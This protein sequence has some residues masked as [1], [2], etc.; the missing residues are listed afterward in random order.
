MGAVAF[1][2]RREIYGECRLAIERGESSRNGVLSGAWCGD[3][4]TGIR[5]RK[6]GER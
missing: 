1:E 3:G 4:R 2:P 5:D 6:Q